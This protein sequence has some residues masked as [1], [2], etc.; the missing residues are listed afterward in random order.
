PPPFKARPPHAD[1]A[2]MFD[3]LRA[4]RELVAK[5]GSDLHLKVGSGPLFRVNGKLA[6]DEASPA[7]SAQDTEAALKQLLT[8]E[9]KLREFAQDREVDYSYEIPGLARFRINAFQ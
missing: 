4:L 7:L 5:N 6:V 3:V 1:H 9:A 8:D 2:G